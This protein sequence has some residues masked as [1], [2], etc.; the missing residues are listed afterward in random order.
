MFYILSQAMRYLYVSTHV[1]S[2]SKQ[3]SPTHRCMKRLAVVLAK[4]LSG[5]KISP[6]WCAGEIVCDRRHIRIL[7][8]TASS[9]APRT[10]QKGAKSEYSR[11]FLPPCR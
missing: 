3:T 10:V 7:R 4:R 8:V 5:Y 1:K 9:T 11:N 2:D 6:L